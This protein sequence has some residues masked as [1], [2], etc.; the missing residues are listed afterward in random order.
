[1]KYTIVDVQ[2]AN[3]IC[4]QCGNKFTEER[5]VVTIVL[6]LSDL[7][8]TATCVCGDCSVTLK[9]GEELK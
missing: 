3:T 8:K 4:N 9:V 2:I 1:M 6:A 7:G 5:P